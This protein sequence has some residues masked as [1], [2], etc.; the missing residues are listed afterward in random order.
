MESS[1]RRSAIPHVARI[2]AAAVLCAIL[3]ACAMPRSADGAEQKAPLPATVSPGDRVLILA[4]HPD[5]ETIA[6]A[7]IIQKVVAAHVPLRIVFLTNGDDNELSFLVYRKHPVILGSSALAMGALR[8]KE[9]IS[10]CGILGVT[11]E[12]LSFLG[13]PDYGT[14]AIWL[15]HWGSAK[16][17]KSLLTHRTRVPYKSAYRF[18][19]S[20]KGEDLLSDLTTI[21]R[22]YRPTK[23]FVSHPADRNGDHWALYLFTKVALWNLSQE[24]R[25]DVYPYLVHFTKWPAKK[26]LYP[27][28]PLE[29]PAELSGRMP[30]KESPLTSHEETVKETALRAH[31]TQMSYSKKF[32]LSFVRT[33]ELFGEPPEILLAEKSE[34]EVDGAG[35]GGGDEEELTD[36]EKG[37]F[38]GL[39]KRLVE[40]DS[41]K[42]ILTVA[43]SRSLGRDVEVSVYIFGY[44]S[45]KDFGNMPK[46]HVRVGP[47]GHAIYDQRKKLPATA[48][49]VKR[50]PK[51]IVIS[52]P[53]ETLGRPQ[54]VITNARTYL[55]E[56]PL[57]SGQWTS[58]DIKS[59]PPTI[60]STA[61]ALESTAKT[62]GAT[63]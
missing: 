25:P 43:L 29:P 61:P 40:L 4:P 60:N 23:I 45:D 57:D 5:D 32:L 1:F 37:S 49:D 22:D 17:Y 10:A 52:I 14:S 9:A 33:N 15:S 44:R 59:A 26:G 2:Y 56:V 24:M 18:D 27:K 51:A 8:E 42:L 34:L 63:R 48:F 20:Y 31:R 16:P 3:A 36:E 41:G 39:G 19:A 6:C 21:I 50:E 30:W 53:L 58:I 55:G 54:K 47:F 62:V 11:R 7:G 13:Y 38:V 12:S 35:G 28:L 46:I